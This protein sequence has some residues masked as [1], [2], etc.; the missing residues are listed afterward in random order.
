MGKSALITGIKFLLKKAD[1]DQ[2]EKIIIAGAFGS[3][4]EKL[5]LIKLGMIPEIDLDK[6]EI[7]GNSAGTGAIM[8][9]CDDHYLDKSKQMADRIETVDLA[10]NIDFQEAFIKNLSFPDEKIK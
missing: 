6:I 10:T 8:T 5:D 9:L 3:H 7:A 2:P 1:L 4:L